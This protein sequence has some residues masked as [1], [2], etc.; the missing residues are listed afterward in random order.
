[1]PF[2][3]NFISFLIFRILEQ[4]HKAYSISSLTFNCFEVSK[5]CSITI[6]IATNRGSALTAYRLK[7]KACCDRLRAR[8]Q[9]FY[10]LVSCFSTTAAEALAVI[11]LSSS[12]SSISDISDLTVSMVF[13]SNML[14]LFLQCFSLD[15]L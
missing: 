4:T 10:L 7:R 11:L 2:V 6:S 8:P 12:I 5:L 15:F 14:L 3:F 1:M 9:G 13:F